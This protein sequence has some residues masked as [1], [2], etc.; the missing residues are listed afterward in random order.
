MEA[1]FWHQRWQSNEI[2][3][4]EGKPNELLARYFQAQ[5]G[6][7]GSRVFLPLCGKT[8]DIGWLLSQGYRVA[9]AEL[10][11]TA[12]E[13]LFTELAIAPERTDLGTHTRYSADGIDILVGDIFELSASMLGTVDVVYDR[14]A[15]VALPEAMRLRYAAHLSRIT[16]NAPQFLL[17]FAYDQTC[18][19]GPPFSVTG[20]EIRR[21]H[22]DRYALEQVTARE[23]AG[24]LKGRC[25]A[26]E[27]L[28]L[29]SPKPSDA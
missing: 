1:G 26:T 13:Q 27:N 8:R 7:Q 23:V 28:W 15:L 21:C 19:D 25:A 9:G 3:F 2:A 24:G 6:A 4:H 22:G 10:S 18:M 5:F 11:G 17:T 14:A 20:E 16:A 29:L 12:I